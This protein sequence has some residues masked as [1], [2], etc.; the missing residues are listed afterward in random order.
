MSDP[1]VLVANRYQGYLAEDGIGPDEASLTWLRA[2]SGEPERVDIG[3]TGGEVLTLGPGWTVRVLHV[4]GHSA[5]HLALLD[6][7]SGALFSGDCLQGAR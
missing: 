6:E 3:F 1:E 2:E 4:P 7:R 5:G